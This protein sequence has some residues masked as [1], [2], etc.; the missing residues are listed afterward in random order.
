MSELNINIPI[1]EV[2]TFCHKWLIKQM[3]IFGSAV[4]DD[5]DPN[6]SDIDILIEFL[7]EASWGFEIATIKQELEDIFKRPIDL[8]SKKA[9]ERSKNPYR[10]KEILDSSKVIYDQAAWFKN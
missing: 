4:R 8:V 7:P 5:F 6:T 1:K 9:V 2:E 10:K 3:A